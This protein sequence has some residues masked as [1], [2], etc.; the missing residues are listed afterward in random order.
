MWN[1]RGLN[2]QVCWES[3]PKFPSFSVRFKVIVVCPEKN[4]NLYIYIYMYYIPSEHVVAILSGLKCLNCSTW[5]WLQPPSPMCQ[6]RRCCVVFQCEKVGDDTHKNQWVEET[7]GEPVK[8]KNNGQIHHEFK[9]VQLFCGG[10]IYMNLVS[11]R[12]DLGKYI[13]T[14]C[15]FLAGWCFEISWTCGCLYLFGTIWNIDLE[16]KDL[17]VKLRHKS[18]SHLIVWFKYY[19]KY[20]MF[21]VPLDSEVFRTSSTNPSSKKTKSTGHTKCGFQK[22]CLSPWKSGCCLFQPPR[23]WSLQSLSGWMWPSN[24]VPT[25]MIFS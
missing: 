5:I 6:S 15:C 11:K 14:H 18:L 4:K 25:P 17:W 3:F 7:T 8:W 13:L 2:F 23:G 10:M 16:F 21:C 24:L 12:D 9:H 20:W 22:T 19:C 1:F